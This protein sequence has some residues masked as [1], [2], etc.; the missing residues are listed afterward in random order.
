MARLRRIDPDAASRT[1][2]F[3]MDFVGLIRGP[4][5]PGEVNIVLPVQFIYVSYD[6]RSSTTL[7]VIYSTGVDV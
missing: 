7:R 3:P 4:D 6:D 2:I 5:S 1:H